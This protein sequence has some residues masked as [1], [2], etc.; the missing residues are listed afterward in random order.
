M[1][2]PKEKNLPPG[3]DVRFTKAE[4]AKY[5]KEWLMDPRNKRCFPMEEEVETED[6]VAR[7]IAFYRYRCSLTATI[8]EVPCGIATLYLQPYK[9]LA[10]QCEFGIIL[11]H[12]YQN[13]GVGGY[14]MNNLMHLAKEKFKIDLLHLQVRADNPAIDFYKRFGFTEFGR[15][16][17]WVKDNDHFGGRVFMERFLT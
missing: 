6:A 12:E 4:D 8:N 14:L 13:K 15:Q 10:H 16:N 5:L 2:K 17:H 3:L 11:G 9:N 1:D 7:W